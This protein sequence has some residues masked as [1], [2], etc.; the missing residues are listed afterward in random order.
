MVQK[1]PADLITQID[2]LITDNDNQEITASRV[3]TV[4][5]DAVDSALFRGENTL[6]D[7][8]IPVVGADGQTMSDSFLS[9]DSEGDDAGIKCSG[10][11]SVGQPEAGKEAVF[12]GGDSYPV[13]GAWHFDEANLTNQTITS[14][15][16][17]TDIL[18]SDSGSTTGLFGGTSSGKCILVC[19]DVA[20]Y[21][22]V[23]VKVNTAGVVEPA[24]VEAN[25]LS[26]LNTWTTA[27]FM[28]SDSDSL[29]QYANLLAARSDSSEQ[30][31]FAFNP[32]DLPVSWEE[33]TMT[34]NSVEYTGYFARFCITS[35]ITTDPIIEQI[36]LHTN[37]FEV[38]SN[39]RTEYFGVARY[40]KTISVINSTNAD[41]NPSNE[42]I[43]IASGIT[44][45]RTDNEFND[46]ASDGFILS[47]VVPEGLDTSIPIQV[48][49]DWYANTTSVGNVELELE[50]V[51]VG[52]AF[53]YDG[54][55]AKVSQT[56]VVTPIDNQQY[57]LQR[58]TFLVDASG[59][60]PQDRI[61]G[62]LFRDATIGN[63]DDTLAGSI[64]VTNYQVL[65]YFWKP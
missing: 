62:S 25:Y 33:L 48:I 19:S 53:V 64:V 46:N 63:A 34:I 58:S 50:T 12:G 61:Y 36:K 30:W 9:Q 20:P 8:N 13:L 49:V 21:G 14:A 11:F 27:P 59:S 40:E 10:Q 3:R 65:G 60:L 18:Q 38:N 29:E 41:K 16:D 24:N 22:G 2:S 51:N 43:S 44:E 28:A 15:I 17:V 35:A 37:R 42:N 7:G 31:R 1:T 26:S 5:T 56:P 54:S 39:G 32:L 45:I 6:T 23:K 55:A 57:E 47:G 4:E 52:E